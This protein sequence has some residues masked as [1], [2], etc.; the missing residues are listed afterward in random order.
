MEEQVRPVLRAVMKL[1]ER[2]RQA[3][4]LKYFAGHEEKQIADLTGQRV[5]TVRVQLS[6]A[7]SRL[8]G[9]PKGLGP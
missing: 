5:G 7:I 9:R 6:R 8:R 4:L 2:H 1:P 3:V